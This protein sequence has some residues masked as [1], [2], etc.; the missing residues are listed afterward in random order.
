MTPRTQESE[1]LWKIFDEAVKKAA[2]SVVQLKDTSH[3]KTNLEIHVKRTHG[4]ILYDKFKKKNYASYFAVEGAADVVWYFPR[5]CSVNPL[6]FT[7]IVKG[8]A[9]DM[10]TYQLPVAKVRNFLEKDLATSESKGRWK[11]KDIEELFSYV[12]ELFEITDVIPLKEIALPIINPGIMPAMAK[13]GSGINNFIGTRLRKARNWIKSCLEE[14]LLSFKA[15]PVAIK[16]CICLPMQEQAF[17]NALSERDSDSEL[18][19]LQYLG[20]KLLK[21]PTDLNAIH[22]TFLEKFKINEN[23]CFVYKTSPVTSE[24]NTTATTGNIESLEDKHE[25]TYFLSPSLSL[26]HF[27]SLSLLPLLLFRSLLLSPMT[28]QSSNRLHTYR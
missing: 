26:T 13:N 19:L 3:P 1:L 24:E 7:V 16:V 15:V 6:H 10:A 23:N 9:K 4:S 27:S 28:T 25:Y 12:P 20:Q 5:D 14:F 21:A 11:V 22:Q 18:K 8:S 17:R 2:N